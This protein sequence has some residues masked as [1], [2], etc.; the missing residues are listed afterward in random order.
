MVVKSRMRRY[1]KKRVGFRRR[2]R[3]SRNIGSSNARRFFKL[4]TVAPVSAPANTILRIPVQ[5][6]P[7]SS[8]EWASCK[9][10]FEMY[11]VCAIKV[12]WIPAANIHAAPASATGFGFQPVY[13]IHDV[14]NVVPVNITEDQVIQYDNLRVKSMSR[15][16]KV[17]YKMVRNI[18]TVSSFTVNTRAYQSTDAPVPTQQLLLFVPA[19]G[20]PQAENLGKVVITFYTVF[21]NRA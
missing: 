2:P 19:L 8:T 1:R 21:K 11:R 3:V 17:Y 20:N 9:A 18:P 4:R 7:Q 15:L 14:N 5:D 10:L 16:W 13:V 6:D 12:T